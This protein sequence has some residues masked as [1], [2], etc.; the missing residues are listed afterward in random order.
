MRAHGRE[1]A[2]QADVSDEIRLTCNQFLKY[3][4][5]QCVQDIVH[6]KKCGKRSVAETFLGSEMVQWLQTVGL[7]SDQGEAL[8]YGSRL[9]EGGVIHHITHDFGFLDDILHYRFT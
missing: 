3:H 8:L 5:E 2:G 1:A 4:K 9:L 6:K 7:A